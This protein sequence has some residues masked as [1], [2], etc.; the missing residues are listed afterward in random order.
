VFLLISSV[1]FLAFAQCFFMAYYGSVEGYQTFQASVMSVLR[2]TVMDFN[3]AA[4]SK[5]RFFT[6]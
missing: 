4:M 2:F 1:I 3:Y 6:Q 5:V